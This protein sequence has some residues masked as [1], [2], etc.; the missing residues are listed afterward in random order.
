MRD[1]L[2]RPARREECRSSPLTAFNHKHH[3][4]LSCA[5]DAPTC[6]RWTASPVSNGKLGS[7]PHSVIDPSYTATFL[8]PNRVSKNASPDAAIPPPQYVITRSLPRAPTEANLRRS[9][10]SGRYA[11]VRG[12]TTPTNETFTL[13]GMCPGRPY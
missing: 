5:Q 8:A 3:D 13:E 2:T 10:S 6:C 12:S 7:A 9:S 4:S 11:F 1:A